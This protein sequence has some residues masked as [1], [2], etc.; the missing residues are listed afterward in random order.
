MVAARAGDVAAVSS[1]LGIDLL[2]DGQ[3]PPRL[4]EEEQWVKARAR[5]INGRAEKGRQWTP[6]M[7]A[8]STG[9]VGES[10][11]RIGV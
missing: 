11:Y 5:L 2:V 3:S 9:Q 4:K 6:M 8:A 10:A 1:M 7:A